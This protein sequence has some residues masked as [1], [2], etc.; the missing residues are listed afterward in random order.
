MKSVNCQEVH[1][2]T[3]RPERKLGCTSVVAQAMPVYVK[4]THPNFAFVAAHSSGASC[5]WFDPGATKGFAT[6]SMNGF[7]HLTTNISFIMI[8]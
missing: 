2:V 3:S 5:E 7:V 8:L 4:K 1:V 6:L